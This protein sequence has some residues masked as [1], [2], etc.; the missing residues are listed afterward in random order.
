MSYKYPFNPY[1]ISDIIHEDP[2]QA[3]IY[4]DTPDATIQVNTNCNPDENIET[5]IKRLFLA[6]EKKITILM[7]LKY[8]HKIQ[9]VLFKAQLWNSDSKSNGTLESL[10]IR[11]K[12]I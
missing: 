3:S 8:I 5:L 12:D 6:S 9:E 11:E 1:W 4:T 2:E 7:A 10:S